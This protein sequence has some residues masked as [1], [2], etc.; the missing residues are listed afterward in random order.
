MKLSKRNILDESMKAFLS[1]IVIAI[2]TIIISAILTGC[3]SQE[4]I[5]AKAPIGVQVEA[6]KVADYQMQISYSGTIEE[7]VSISLSFPITGLV[8]RVL[9]LQGQKIR[10]G[11]LLAYVNGE[12]FKNSYELSLAKQKQ[13]EDAYHR[14]EP[15]FKNATMPE[16][17]MVE[18]QTGLKQ[19]VAATAIAKKNWD[20]CKLYAPA[21]GVIG[22]RS[23]EPGM[24]VIPGVSVFTL[25]QIE[26]VFVR[27]P[28]PENEISKITKDQ[29]SEIEIPALG[30]QLFYGKV[31][32]IGVMA[33]I[34]TRSYDIKIGLANPEGTI[35]PGMVCNVR[36]KSTAKARVL[37][38]P[39]HVVQV[40][41]NGIN[42]VYVANLKQGVAQKR[43]VLIGPILK[44]GICITQGLN[45]NE[46]IIVSGMQKLADNS[47]I[48]VIE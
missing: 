5:P 42:F 36:L 43:K 25:V 15:M 22:K 31:E 48:R 24:N 20:D 12:S 14:F 26:K 34:M 18:I 33:N 4:I 9:V 44:E 41:E 27:F 13:A 39:N 2:I 46:K 29:T 6:A 40:D 1:S 17:K 23:L 38:V 10:K 47:A 45:S 11:Q 37:V 8:D 30:A 19:S 21:D 16:I 7:S 28:V 35:R 32:E 3:H